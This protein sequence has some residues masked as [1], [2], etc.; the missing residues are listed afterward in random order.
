[1]T[2]P[3]SG[4]F[5]R[6]GGM[7]LLQAAPLRCQSHGLSTRRNKKI[8]S[9]SLRPRFRQLAACSVPSGLPSCRPGLAGA[10]FRRAGC[11][12][13]ERRR[14]HS[15]ARRTRSLS[16]SV[17]LVHY[18]SRLTRGRHTQD[19]QKSPGSSSKLSSFLRLQPAAEPCAPE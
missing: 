7:T 14:C 11:P 3:S 8:L 19:T 4:L 1:M 16:L 15:L 9:L 6:P 10:E 13:R 12:V 5:L 18:H 17:F 2:Q